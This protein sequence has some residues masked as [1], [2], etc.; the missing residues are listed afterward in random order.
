MF[1]Q[2]KLVGWFTFLYKTETYQ[3]FSSVLW[4][5]QG[6]EDGGRGSGVL[7]IQQLPVVSCFPSSIWMTSPVWNKSGRIQ[8]CSHVKRWSYSTAYLIIFWLEC[9]FFCC[10]LFF[11]IFTFFHI[12][13]NSRQH[14]QSSVKGLTTV[15]TRVHLIVVPFALFQD[16]SSHCGI[17]CMPTFHFYKNG[18]KVDEFSGANLQTLITKVESLRS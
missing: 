6:G 10:C 1:K 12:I 13:S 4:E 15:T 8:I 17:N 11:L 3:L 9:I 16:V 7:L 18:Q 2:I 14:D 5:T